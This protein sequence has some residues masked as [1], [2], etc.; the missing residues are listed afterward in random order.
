MQQLSS[1]NGAAGPAECAAAVVDVALTVTR[2]VRR[3]I[4]HGAVPGLTVPQLR[5]LGFINADP[6]CAPS[7]LAEYLMLGRPAV[8]RLLDGLVRR[9]LITRRPHADDRRRVQLSLTRTGLAHVEGYFAQ[10][11]EIV[12]ERLSELAPRDRA[13]LLRAMHL[14]LPL[15]AGSTPAPVHAQDG[16][17]EHRA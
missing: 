5:A 15:V 8:T 7:Q 14:V 2:L 6:E 13:A 10:A 12:A 3:Q 11:R 9:R 17:S 16:S 1:G 4:R